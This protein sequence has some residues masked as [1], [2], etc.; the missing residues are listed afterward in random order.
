MK[1]VFFIFSLFIGLNTAFSQESQNKYLELGLEVQQYPTG[2]LLGARGEIGLKTHH[3]IDFRLGYN[4][5]DHEDFGVHDS[6]I[7]GGFGG[8]VGYR[9]YFNPEH[10]NWFVGA[11][12]DLWNNEVDWFDLDPDSGE[13]IAEGTSNIFVLQPTILGGYRWAINPH[14]ALAGTLA[15]GAEI[16]IVTN[17]AEIGQG[18]ILLWGLS[19]TYRW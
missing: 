19:F 10:K 2:F 16:N 13:V 17:G 12:T 18:P 9:Y 5:L 14:L 11:R 1:F 6:E 4:V 15:A 7:G 8:S 3:A